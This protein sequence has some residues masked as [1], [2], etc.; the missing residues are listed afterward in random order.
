MIMLQDA[1]EDTELDEE[2]DEDVEAAKAEIWRS[3]I[4]T[5]YTD[6]TILQ[7]TLKLTQRRH[8]FLLQLRL[9]Q[10]LHSTTLAPLLQG[11]VS[12]YPNQKSAYFTGTV[13]SSWQQ[14]QTK[15]GP[16]Y[17]GD[18]QKGILAWAGLLLQGKVS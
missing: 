16:L 13:F 14:N 12:G 4:Y 1:I 17:R 8:Q 3:G 10:H 5:K 9:S 2:V 18:T 6:S 7:I 15:F 11:G